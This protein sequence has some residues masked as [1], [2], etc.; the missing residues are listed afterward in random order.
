[1]ALEFSYYE[2]SDRGD[3]ITA[4]KPTKSVNS[5]KKHRNASKVSSFIYFIEKKSKNKV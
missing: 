1:M 5:H 2:E 4:K 3:T